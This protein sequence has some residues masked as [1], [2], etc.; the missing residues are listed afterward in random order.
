MRGG[1][2]L[3]SRVPSDA[4]KDGD[5]VTGDWAASGGDP[6][7]IEMGRV[8]VSDLRHLQEGW[9]GGRVDD[10][11]L[12]RDSGILRRLLI[13]NGG[14]L[15]R[16]YRRRAG[17]KGEIKVE[18]QDLGRQLVGT[19]R[20]HL[21]FAAAGGGTHAGMTVAAVSVHSVA[22]SADE[23]R[24][25]YE[26]GMPT[27]VFGLSKFLDSPCLILD[28]RSIN[29]RDLIK[30]VTNRLGGV[31]FDENRDPVTERAFLAL[32]RIMGTISIAEKNVVYFELLSVGQAI[33]GSAQVTEMLSG[34]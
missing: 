31:H 25:Q 2:W 34:P 28:G 7:L 10:D 14:G 16:T 23:V 15:L 21:R 1:F 24:A 20:K 26:R 29:R 19:D 5:P 6:G 4:R 18:A 9:D 32:D 8:I 13:D 22:M 3:G 33:L 17:L 30:Y 27:S 11:R 12:R